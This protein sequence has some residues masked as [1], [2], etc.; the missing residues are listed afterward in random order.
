MTAH[1]EFLKFAINIAK[2]AGDIQLPYFGN[3]SKISKKSNAIDLLTNVDIESEE[4]IISKIK[5]R[6]PDHSIISEESEQID[7]KSR[8][9]WIIDPLDGTTNFAHNLPIF[10]VSIGLKENNKTIC[11]VV[12]NPAA[13]KCFTAQ[14]GKGAHLNNKKIKAS[15]ST[16]LSE[17]LLATGFPYL[18]DEKYDLSFDLFKN[19]YD[20]TRGLRRLGS[21]ALDLC[22]VAMG[23]FDGFYEFNLNSWDVC[24]GSLIASEAGCTISDW[25]GNK[26][27]DCG[28]RI[29]CTN[30]KIHNEMINILKQ[31]KY[32]IFF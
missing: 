24:A 14:V 10:A 1:S 6:Y 13:N 30:G 2:D 16:L 4:Y 28:K 27:P 29:L 11:A 17:S 20:R 31:K 32:S 12:Y 21:A 7:N 5:K 9:Q 18:R 25:D 26:A 23:R 19:F 8:Y 15:T 3:I 22:F